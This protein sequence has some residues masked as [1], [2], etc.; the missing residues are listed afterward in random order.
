MPSVTSQP[1]A[2][3]EWVNAGPV[4]PS[5]HNGRRKS[6]SLITKAQQAQQAQQR[7]RDSEKAHCPVAAA[8]SA[9][10]N[11]LAMQERLVAPVRDG[12]RAAESPSKAGGKACPGCARLVQGHFKFCQFCGSPLAKAH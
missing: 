9:L 12:D 6:N 10:Q 1:T 2:E 4:T 3:V 8:A 5:K 7:H 11:C